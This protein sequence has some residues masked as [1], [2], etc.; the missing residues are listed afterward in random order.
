M[1]KIKILNVGQGSSIIIEHIKDGISHY[2]V[3]DSN[4]VGA[5]IPRAL[6]ELRAVGAK[7]LSFI[8]LTHP[9]QDHYRGMYDVISAFH[10][11]IRGFYTCPFGDLMVNRDRFKK[12][13]THLRNL[14]RTAGGEKQRKAAFEMAQILLWADKSGVAW[15]EC[16][17]D[18]NAIAPF[19]F[20][21]VDIHTLTPARVSKGNYVARIDSGDPWMFGHI[22]DNDISLSFRVAYQGFNIVLG[23][24]ASASAWGLRKKY[25]V[26]SGKSI[27]AKA[28][29]LPHH[30]SVYDCPP[31]VL[32][33][34]FSGDEDRYGLTSAGGLSHPS[35]EIIDWMYSNSIDPYCTNLI[36]E[37]GN[38]TSQIYPL[39]T[40]DK[41]LARTLREAAKLTGVQQVC[42]GDITIVID[43]GSMSVTPQHNH[44]CAFRK[45]A[46]TLFGPIPQPG[47]PSSPPPSQSTPL[48][49]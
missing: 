15:Y 12:F 36:A 39:G 30:G 1:L 48:P 17:G 21:G 41:E 7:E 31:E 8:A 5:G 38:N 13:G 49:P 25:E 29:N 9:H 44:F 26:Q 2:G 46:P 10:G 4:H 34:L 47:T 24:D 11:K 33:R 40:L 43:N 23:G 27:S 28:V 3:V 14:S 22:D 19:G 37:C 18:E 16:A 32:S 45:S 42:Q 20:A 6:S 35:I